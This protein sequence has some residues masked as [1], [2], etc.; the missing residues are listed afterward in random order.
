MAK[1]PPIWII[2]SAN[3]DYSIFAATLPNIGETVF[4]TSVIKA[5][6]GKGLNQAVAVMRAGGQV[7]FYFARGQDDDGEFISNSLSE[8]NLPYSAVL[9]D[10]LNT[11]C[12]YIL[13][14]NK[15]ENQIVVV[16]GANFST[17]LSEHNFADPAGWLVL[18]LEIGQLNNAALVAKAKQAGWKIVLTPAPA[19]EFDRELLASVD[20]LTLNQSESAQISGMDNLED[21]GISLSSQVETVFITQ[22]ASGVTVFQSGQLMGHISALRVNATDATGAGDTFCGYVVTS[23]AQGFDSLSAARLAT[24]AAG[25]SVQHPG[26][27]GSIP[28]RAEVEA[29]M[30]SQTD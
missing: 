21:A 2:G 12:A 7:Q 29:L 18:Q 25:M 11:G 8:L 17:K 14:D 1:N 16:P 3:C 6:G 20:V 19:S 30:G 13:V 28:I 15:G 10:K 27:V 24:A 26:A 23:L 9:D 22:G 4:G 5:P